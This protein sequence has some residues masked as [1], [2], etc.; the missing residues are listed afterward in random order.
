MRTEE[1]RKIEYPKIEGLSSIYPSPTVLVGRTI[2]AE[3][4]RD[5]SCVGFY[6]DENKDLQMRSREMIRADSEM[7]SKFKMI[8]GG[9]LWLRI[10]EF[11]IESMEM[12]D[13]IVPFGEFFRKGKSPARFEVHEDHG[14][15]LFDVWSTKHNGFVH[16]ADVMIV[17]SCLN[18]A[19]PL[20]YGAC[21]PES[22]NE[23]Q[24]FKDE[25]FTAAVAKGKEGIVFKTYATEKVPYTVFFKERQ[26]KAAKPEKEPKKYEVP[27]LPPLD[28][29]QIRGAIDKAYMDLGREDFANTKKAMPKVVEYVNHEADKH[30]CA[31]PKNIFEYYKEF[32]DEVVASEL[33]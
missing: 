28:D 22:F 31:K 14:F 20:V 19:G 1:I 11:L 13:E 26:H 23:L 7:Y 8:E 24:K 32:L 18:V 4:K 2:I 30:G 27:Q 9:A 33:V 16:L 3:E 21:T 10:R 6:L 15:M 17:A 5:G 12:G 29:G 25:M